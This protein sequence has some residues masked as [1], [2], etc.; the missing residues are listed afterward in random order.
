M[1][2]NDAMAWVHAARIES[3]HDL[4]GLA[5]A[6]A[7]LAFVEHRQATRCVRWPRGW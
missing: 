6:G 5:P 4:H 1:W 3:L 7:S 2:I